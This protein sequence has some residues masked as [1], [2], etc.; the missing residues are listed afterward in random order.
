MMSVTAD[1]KQP[2]HD[3]V[4]PHNVIQVALRKF[5]HGFLEMCAVPNPRDDR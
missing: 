1:N 5:V 4:E 3:F 2:P